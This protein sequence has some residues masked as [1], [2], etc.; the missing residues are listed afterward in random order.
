MRFTVIITFI[1]SILSS[2]QV[3]AATE[4]LRGKITSNEWVEFT[5]FQER[6]SKRYNSVVE[7][8]HRFGTFKENLQ[9]IIEHNL[10]T[11][12]NFKLNV[13]QFTD[14]NSTEFKSMY[15]S[16]LKIGTEVGSYMI[17]SLFLQQQLMLLI[18]L[19]GEMKVLLQ[20]LKI[21][22][23]VAHVGHFHQLVL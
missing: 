11:T 9:H 19:I 23:N 7:L 12:N 4:N 18:L 3:D 22:D 14:L 16:G 20:Q 21:K 5:S 8:E 15:V 13:N 17:V 1:A 10:D 2:A 6:F